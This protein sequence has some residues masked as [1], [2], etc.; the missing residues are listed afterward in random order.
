MEYSRYLMGRRISRETYWIIWLI[1]DCILLVTCVISSGAGNDMAL[2]V[3]LMVEIGSILFMTV[4]GVFRM[5]DVDRSG[6]YLLVPG[7]NLV[8]LFRP[9]IYVPRVP[10]KTLLPRARFGRAPAGEN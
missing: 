1:V 9:S 8:L 10:A 6:W 4:L 7:Y 3:A 5:H 2:F